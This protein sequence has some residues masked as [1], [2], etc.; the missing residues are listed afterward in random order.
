MISE[1]YTGGQTLLAQIKAESLKNNQK[2]SKILQTFLFNCRH[3]LQ[4]SVATAVLLSVGITDLAYAND[5]SIDKLKIRQALD[6]FKQHYSSQ[7]ANYVQPLLLD[8]FTNES[9]PTFISVNDGKMIAA[10]SVVVEKDMY[11]SNVRGKLMGNQIPQWIGSFSAGNNFSSN[12]NQQDNQPQVFRPQLT[13]PTGFMISGG[14]SNTGTPY[15]EKFKAR[16]I[17]QCQGNEKFT[18]TRRPARKI[19]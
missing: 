2:A 14:A 4:T 15:L 18:R 3:S 19:S 16:S 7:A 6:T 13:A 10:N 5:G 1:V 8:D 11:L 9:Y 17:D 12:F